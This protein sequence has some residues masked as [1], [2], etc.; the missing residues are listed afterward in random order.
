MGPNKLTP[1]KSFLWMLAVNRH[2]KDNLV[3]QSLTNV[4]QWILASLIAKD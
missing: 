2:L 1:K 4:N 3:K